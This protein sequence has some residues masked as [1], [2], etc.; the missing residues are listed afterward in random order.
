MT[1]KEL[2]EKLDIV[3]NLIEAFD[4][5][6]ETTRNTMNLFYEINHPKYYR[7]K[8]DFEMQFLAQNRL[9]LYF[10][11]LRKESIIELR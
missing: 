5:R 2:I 7:K 3:D 9:I 10:E 6:R 8:K 1:R 4:I 11:K